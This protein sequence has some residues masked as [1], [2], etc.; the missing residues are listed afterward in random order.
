M[1]NHGNLTA[2]YGHSWE[3]SPILAET[4]GAWVTLSHRSS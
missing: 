1:D 3:A 4:P 2:A